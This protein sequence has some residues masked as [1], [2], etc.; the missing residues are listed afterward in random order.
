M[1]EGMLSEENVRGLMAARAPSIM[2][3]RHGEKPGGRFAGVTEWGETNAHD[4]S[5]RGW[6][7]AMDLS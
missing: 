4:L 2:V 6:Q 7:R 3:I 5:V 1:W